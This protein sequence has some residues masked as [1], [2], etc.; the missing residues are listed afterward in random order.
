[1][2]KH[3]VV[4]VEDLSYDYHGTNA[5]L[6]VSFQ[7]EQGQRVALVGPNGAG[8]STLLLH[9]VGLLEGTGAVRIRGRR[10][11]KKT[12]PWVRSEVGL[13]FAD[14]EDQLFMPTLI[15]DAAFGPLNMGLGKDEAFQRASS[16]LVR[17]GLE[18]KEQ[19]SPHHL[20]D[21]ERRRAAIATVLSMDPSVWVFD[22][23][24]ANLD[25]RA[26]RDLIATLKGLPGS[27]ILA[28]HDLDLV[29]QV[30]ERC[31]LLDAG[32]LIADQPTEEML[33]NEALMEEHGLEVPLRLKLKA[34]K[35]LEQ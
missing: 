21:G 25:P 17:M 8:K 29:T 15:Q 26:R 7:I 32:R 22:E 35:E 9:L 10:L 13:V 20:S 19:R 1:L 16:S 23:P 31:M 18:D 12:M 3:P 28:S 14:P 30:C 6:G 4:Q 33:Q 27:V 5:L 2:S 24:A 34:F 11:E